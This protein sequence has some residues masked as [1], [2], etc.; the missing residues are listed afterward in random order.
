MMVVSRATPAS[1]GKDENILVQFKNI[2][3]ILQASLVSILEK[4]ELELY[5]ALQ[6]TDQNSSE[7]ISRIR[8]ELKFLLLCSKLEKFYEEQKDQVSISKIYLLIILHIYY[9]NQES[10]K[11]MIERFN[12]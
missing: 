1:S 5:K 7:Y 4:L 12:L 10:I 3:S 8:D 9:K 11:K 6:Y 2:T